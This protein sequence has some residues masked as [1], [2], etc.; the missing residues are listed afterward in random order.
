MALIEE[1]KAFYRENGY[2]KDVSVS[3]ILSVRRSE[4]RWL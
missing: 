2:L 3:G 4:W 1:Q